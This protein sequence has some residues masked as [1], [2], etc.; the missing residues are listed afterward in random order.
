MEHRRFSQVVDDD[1]LDAMES[2]L[3]TWGYPRGLVEG[4]R[5][6]STFIRYGDDCIFWFNIHAET[7]LNFHVCVD[8]SSRGKISYRRFFTGVEVIAELL[9]ASHLQATLVERD[10][11]ELRSYCQRLGWRKNEQGYIRL[12]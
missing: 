12:L 3:T 11:I 4:E 9:G 8:P 1:E 7:G 2:D 6:H 10:E 5:E